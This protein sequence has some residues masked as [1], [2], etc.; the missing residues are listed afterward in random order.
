MVTNIKLFEGARNDF[1]GIRAQTVEL[2]DPLELCLRLG[3][4]GF[5]VT[6]VADQGP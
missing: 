4:P 2:A 3:R 6:L 5:I 1:K